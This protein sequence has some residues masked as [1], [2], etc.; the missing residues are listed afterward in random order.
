MNPCS[1]AFDVDGYGPKVDEIDDGE[2]DA[3]GDVREAL[4]VVAAA[5]DSD[6]QAVLSRALDGGLDVGG[7]GGGDDELGFG[8][9][10]RSES[11]VYYGEI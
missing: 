6:L 11:R 7:V 1:S 2:G 3:A 4:V 10:W 8:G 9:G 5:S